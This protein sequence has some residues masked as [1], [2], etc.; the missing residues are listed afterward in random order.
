MGSHGQSF[1]RRAGYVSSVAIPMTNSPENTELEGVPIQVS[2]AT[3]SDRL[4]WNEY[5]ESQPLAEIYHRFEWKSLLEGVFG[6]QCHYLIARNASGNV[7]GV[8]P[9]SHLNSRLFGNFLISIPCFNYCGVL[10]EAR[11]TRDALVAFAAELGKEVG[12][13]HIELR[14]RSHV[15]LD[16]PFRDH[17]V[18]MQLEL[19]GS[20]DDLWTQF[21]AKLRSQIRRPQKEGAVCDEGG[22]ELLD[23]FYSVFSRNMRDLGT[24]VYPKQLFRSMLESFPDSARLFVVRFNAKAVAAGITIGYRSVLEIPSA[25]ALREYNRVSVNMLLY[26]SVLQYA[27]KNGY[28][29]FDFG[30]SSIDA[31]TFRFK[32]QWGASP[33][34]LRWHYY[35]GEGVDI[36]H[37]NP[38]NPKFKFATRMWQFLPLP[39]ANLLGPKI[40]RHLP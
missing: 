10:A 15:S 37:L 19:P 40:V 26:W 3:D 9:L 4:D 17:K 27:I 22:V 36:P 39:V 33:Q 5:V 25:S 38:S 8:L 23:D 13:A 11:V 7:K 24:P 29:I 31:G 18:S 2:V 14:H 21:P 34:Q 6:H 32:K 30:R 28:R 20:S 35:L 16:L 12:A 1:S